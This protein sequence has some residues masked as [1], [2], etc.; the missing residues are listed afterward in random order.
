ML[1]GIAYGL[2]C[3]LVQN[4][5]H[6]FSMSPALIHGIAF[7]WTRCLVLYRVVLRYIEKWCKMLPSRW[8]LFMINIDNDMPLTGGYLHIAYHHVKQCTK[9]GS[10]AL[11]LVLTFSVLC[12]LCICRLKM[13]SS[14]LFAKHFI[15]CLNVMTTSAIS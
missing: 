10:S 11:L 6:W 3:R 1:H 13:F 2:L 14:R 12:N 9:S 8:K 7:D 5:K 4:R 15:L